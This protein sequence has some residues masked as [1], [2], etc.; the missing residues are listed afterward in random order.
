MDNMQF[1]EYVLSL[2]T[3]SGHVITSVPVYVN[4]TSG[5]TLY[6]DS[7]K[8]VMINRFD[9]ELLALIDNVSLLADIKW[10][11]VVDDLDENVH[12]FSIVV[13]FS[14]RVRSQY[15][16]DIHHLLQRYWSCTHSIIFF[17]NRENY[18]IS[19]ADPDR[20]HILSDWRKI[21]TTYD[22]VVEYIGIENISLDNCENYFLDFLYAIA[23]EYC[24]HPISFEEASYGLMPIDYI[25]KSLSSDIPV[26]RVEI[27]EMIRDNLVFYERLYGDDYV[28][29]VY[30]GMDE[31]VKYHNISDEIDRISFELELDEDADNDHLSQFGFEDDDYV[32]DTEDD[33]FDDYDEDIDPAIF[34]DPVLMVK[35][36]EKKQKERESNSDGEPT[37]DVVRR[38][39]ERI[40]AAARRE[41]ERL[42]AIRKE[43]ERIE[44][45]RREQER[46]DAIRKEQERMEAARREQE[47][48][49]AIRK[50][51][52]RIEAAR[53]EQEQMDA[54]HK[55]LL[56]V[57]NQIYN[58]ALL[59]EQKRIESERIARIHLIC[60]RNRLQC[61]LK[62]ILLF[63]EEQECMEAARREQERLDAI[64][65]EQEHIEAAR[66]EQ[67]RLDAI[68]KEQERIEAARREQER[69]DAERQRLLSQLENAHLKKMK[70][71][72]SQ[73][74]SEKQRLS[75]ELS[76]VD[77]FIQ[78]KNTRLSKLSFLQFIEKRTLSA[79]LDEL[80]KKKQKLLLLIRDIE[81]KYV[82]QCDRERV[83]FNLFLA[84]KGL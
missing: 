79:E 12:I 27:K 31:L 58:L 3:E 42:D 21:D 49:D 35:W 81:I 34:D 75:N 84:Q 45:T 54:K 6:I 40:D 74:L 33:V 23:R 46:L 17:K 61:I 52:E 43:Q 25:S 30:T 56:L 70:E 26:S 19:F 63:R 55:E 47:R 20:S 18:I 71:I 82:E 76:Q 50:E 37:E 38:E 41:Q 51:Q 64:R 69:L 1:Y 4:H 60:E 7:S 68:R 2:L 65:R 83:D 5:E 44:A 9:R 16:A 67:E 24:I 66:R 36:L 78:E 15:V 29:P 73:Y 62:E 39:Q 10:Q 13:D 57:L 32:E 11:G 14:E 22:D 28:E 59:K 48:L 72:E 80:N 77:R 53:R 8:D